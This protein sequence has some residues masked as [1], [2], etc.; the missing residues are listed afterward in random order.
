MTEEER[1]EVYKALSAA[2]SAFWRVRR[3]NRTFT[4]CMNY[5]RAKK[6]ASLTRTDHIFKKYCPEHLREALEAQ[7]KLE[8]LL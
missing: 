1:E 5:Q 4:I 2:R 6:A 8:G 3:A 7:C